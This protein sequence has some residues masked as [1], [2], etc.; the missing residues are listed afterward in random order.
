LMRSHNPV[1]GVGRFAWTRAASMLV[2]TANA[3]TITI[4]A[5]E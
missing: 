4:V 2:K 3:P 5:N 1:H